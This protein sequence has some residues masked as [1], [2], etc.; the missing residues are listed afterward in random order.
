MRRGK[1]TTE[2][3]SPQISFLSGMLTGSVAQ[4]LADMSWRIV[5]AEPGYTEVMTPSKMRLRIVVEEI[6]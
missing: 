6:R 3:M 5:K 4:L 2:V 1:A